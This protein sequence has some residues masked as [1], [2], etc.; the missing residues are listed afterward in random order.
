MWLSF[1][2]FS[3][4]AEINVI[5]ITDAVTVIT[6]KE[7]NVHCPMIVTELQQVM[8]N[9]YNVDY[10]YNTVFYLKYNRKSN[11]SNTY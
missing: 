4:V 6:I 10:N 1:I 7:N 2:L 9:V 5:L 11:K 8:L 3:N